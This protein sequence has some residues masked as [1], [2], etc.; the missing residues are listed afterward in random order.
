MSF[1]Q[2][3]L[4]KSPVEHEDAIAG[5]QAENLRLHR[6]NA[7]RRD[8]NAKL[9]RENGKLRE[10]NAKLH[11]ENEKLREIFTFASAEFEKRNKEIE[12]LR[13]DL[14]RAHTR[15]NVLEKE[16][17][18]LKDEL[19][20]ERA[21][22]HL[23]NKF[24]F[25]GR[26]TEKKEEEE[27]PAEHKKRGASAG[28]KGNGRKIPKE[29]PV[30]EEIIDIPDKDKFCPDCGLPYED[31]EMEETSSEIAV[32]KFYYVKRHRR[33][34][35]KK[36]CKCSGRIV[37]APLPKKLIPKGKCAA[38]F[39]I[40]ILINKYKNHLPVERQIRDML[41]Y[42]L[43]V[44]SGTIFGGLKKIHL[45]YL[46]PLYQALMKSL[47]EANHIHMDE[48]GWKLFILLGE[49]ENNNCFIW[50]FVSKDVALFAIRPGRGASVPCKTLFDMD[51][52]EIKLLGENPLEKKLI[53]VDK[54][55]SYKT[56]ER[57]KLV[58]R[59]ICWSHERRE[60][61]DAGTKYPE[62]SE[63]S[64]DWIE[65]IAAIYHLNNER[66][67]RRRGSSSFRKFDMELRGKM[68]EIYL[69]I[70][71]DHKHP[72]QVSVIESMKN[73]WVGLTLF[74]DNPD[75]PMDNNLSER[76]L[77][78]PVLGRK[79]YWGNHSPWAAE[80]T[81]AM[82]SLIQTCILNDISPRAYLAYYFEE[83]VNRGKAPS[84]DEID[85][86][87]PNKLNPEVREKLRLNKPEGSASPS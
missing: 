39:W 14:G 24:A 16:V 54:F 13:E 62:L 22:V 71:Q 20:K 33:K 40:D 53:T 26:K 76:M 9:R 68:D 75:I 31:T 25:G 67:K 44:N 18:S 17:V 2:L 78:G 32:E 69:L 87:L 73:H 7:N 82:Y 48:S 51:I 5:L 45:L 85:S 83:C 46:E 80:L 58:D 27:K 49:K 4:E 65:R 84:E 35:Y 64:D 12:R 15:M 38:S 23:L 36:T 28:H 86:F 60:F 57:L 59:S 47:R 3:A 34:K 19:T 42:G 66:V 37:I 43:P 70:N 10:E 41:E 63:W 30:K 1:E 50:V 6:E 11:R 77:R 56:L 29:L 81:G 21:K 61:I 72:G 52:E 74:V 79:N 8:E 55:S